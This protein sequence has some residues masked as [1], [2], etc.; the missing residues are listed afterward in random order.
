MDVGFRLV[1]ARILSK[2]GVHPNVIVCCDVDRAGIEGH[3]GVD[4]DEDEDLASDALFG[5]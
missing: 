3:E 4:L 5:P 1:K 2:L